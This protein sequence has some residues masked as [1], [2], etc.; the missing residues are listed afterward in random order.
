[1]PRFGVRRKWPE[2]VIP[3][4]NAAA[5][6][7]PVGGEGIG[8]ALRSAEMAAEV[9]G[10]ALA[11]KPPVAQMQR[12][13]AAEFRKLW[14]TRSV[15]WR[16]VGMVVSR[17]VW[18]EMAVRMMNVTRVAERVV[19]LGKTDAACPPEAPTKMIG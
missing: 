5:A 9:I 16:A 14:K 18:C 12:T 7:E 17:P 4:G 6:I 15:L 3:I 10:D 11:D 2:G 19:A 8:L 13:L 1:L